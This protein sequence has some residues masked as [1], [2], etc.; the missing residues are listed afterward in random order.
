MTVLEWLLLKPPSIRFVDLRTPSL[1]AFWHKLRLSVNI[2]QVPER[3]PGAWPWWSVALWQPGAFRLTITRIRRAVRE[4]GNWQLKDLWEADFRWLVPVHPLPR[5]LSLSSRRI[6]QVVMLGLNSLKGPEMRSSFLRGVQVSHLNGT[7]L[8]SAQE[9][10]S[11]GHLSWVPPEVENLLSQLNAKW[12][13]TWSES[14]WKVV[15]QTVWKSLLPARLKMLLWRL[16]H[17]GVWMAQKAAAMQL[18]LPQCPF[19]HQVETQA[20][21]FFLCT[22]LRPVWCSIGGS[23]G[24]LATSGNLPCFL[25]ALRSGNGCNQANL[26]LVGCLL[27]E[28]WHTRAES[29]GAIMPIHP[30]PARTVALLRTVVSS[31]HQ[32][33]ND[34]QRRRSIQRVRAALAAFGPF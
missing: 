2:S 11:V 13:V 4:L 8:G 26:L 12:N 23:F 28:V 34:Q 27:W 15:W 10:L 24:G 21:A 16:L 29:I 7:D 6:F 32:L 31:F 19:C 33:N 5:D 14:E 3:L 18:G 22:A 30:S 25:A 9:L 20:H 1:L 17:H